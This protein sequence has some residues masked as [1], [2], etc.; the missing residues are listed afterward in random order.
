MDNYMKYG[1]ST[2]A[3][4]DD[5]LYKNWESDFIKYLKD[6]GFS[7]WGRKGYFGG[8][9]MFVNLN[10][11]RYAFLWPGVGFTEPIAKKYISIEDFKIIYNIF[12]KY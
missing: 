4:K 2:I 8:N 9:I 10:S 6:N 12:E 5:D 1:D 7:N 3:V 11:K